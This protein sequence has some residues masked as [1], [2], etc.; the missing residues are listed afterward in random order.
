MK[1]MFLPSKLPFIAVIVLCSM[2]VSCSTFSSKD[3]N[4]C[5]RNSELPSHIVKPCGEIWAYLMKGEEKEFSGK[6]PI[7]DLCYFSAELDFEGRLKGPEK[8]PDSVVIQRSIRKHLVIADISHPALLHFCMDRN[9][10]VRNRL[11]D[12]ISEMAASYD[13][14]Q[15]DFESIEN[16]D[17][18][19][20]YSF[21][22]ELKQKNSLKIISVAVPA[23][24]ASLTKDPYDYAMLG[25][26]ADRIII[27]A[28][29]EHWSRSKPGPVASL[30]WCD[31]IADYALSVLP[32]NRIVMGIP[33]YGR[34]WQDKELARSI[35]SKN[36]PDILSHHSLDIR[37]DENG[38]PEIEYEEEVKVTV[39]CETAA[40]IMR[41]AN[42]YREKEIANL[43]F[44]RIGQEPKTVWMY[45]K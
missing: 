2:A 37:T 18:E 6:E 16:E 40:T 1:I 5:R 15:I 8:L 45:L 3:T 32:E 34:A 31:K 22:K 28:Y 35:R 24:L 36:A 29:D 43:A 38:T 19:P 11:I 21:V 42:L 23:H 41:K 26:C 13:G 20:F 12:S 39:Y 9:F 44:W 30:G 17:A 4:H 7:T 27:M 25:R 14:I 10:P 33:F